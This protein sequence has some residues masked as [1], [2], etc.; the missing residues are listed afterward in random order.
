MNS[1]YS[2]MSLRKEGAQLEEKDALMQMAET[3]DPKVY[4]AA[5]VNFI[6]QKNTPPEILLITKKA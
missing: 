6:N 3:L 5:Y 4:H 2:D 1:S